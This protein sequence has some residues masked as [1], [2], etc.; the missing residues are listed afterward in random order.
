MLPRDTAIGTLGTRCAACLNPTRHLRSVLLI[1]R[2]DPHHH[3]I[4]PFFMALHPLVIVGKP[5]KEAQQALQARPATRRQPPVVH[6][7]K[8]SRCEVPHFDK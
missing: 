8:F 5:L 7:V 4:R 2:E 1:I 6:L 3:D